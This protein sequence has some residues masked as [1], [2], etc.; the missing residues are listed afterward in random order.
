MIKEKDNPMDIRVRA[1]FA[2]FK[3][4]YLS[5]FEHQLLFIIKISVSHFL[6]IY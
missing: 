1:R 3:Y 2:A 6:F 5:V 4:W